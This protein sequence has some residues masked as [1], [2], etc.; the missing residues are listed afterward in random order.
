MKFFIFAVVA[1]GFL[2]L[3]PACRRDSNATAA[4]FR[5]KEG[6]FL[7]YNVN[8][9]RME[10]TVGREFC[11]QRLP[12]ASTFKVPLALMAFDS[13][14]LKDENQVFKWDG[15]K[16]MPAWD[17]DHNA[18]TWMRDSV[19]WF[20]QRLTPMIGEAGMK[21]YLH[22]FHYGN[23]DI[24]GGLTKAWL[25]PPDS[26][27]P[28]LSISAFEQ[29]E[30]LRAFFDGR[31]GVSERATNL[32]RKIFFLENTDHGWK[33]SGKTGSNYY[34]KTEN[35]RLGWFIGHLER[36]GEQY[37]F[38]TVFRDL[39]PSEDRQYGGRAAKAMT[40]DLLIEKNLW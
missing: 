10:V 32:T 11:E 3:Q 27:P 30:F 7:L 23:E 6:C 8:K 38:V 29:I 36:G 5:N 2:F 24:S 4:A 39:G 14:V 1:A 15:K 19:V 16:M 25:L 9:A 18:T 17:H 33:L 26:A 35:V 40:K 20:S 13:G 21:K 28:A 22:Q 34:D 37:F 12:A 31:L